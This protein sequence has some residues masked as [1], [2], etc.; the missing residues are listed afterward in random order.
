MYFSVPRF[1]L[2]ETEDSSYIDIPSWKEKCKE[3]GGIDLAL[4][5]KL[6]EFNEIVKATEKR[7]SDYVLLNLK[8]D[9]ARDSM[10][11][12]NGKPVILR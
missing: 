10:F 11:K 4:T 1:F 3:L 5:V 2:A 7:K 12:A 6:D 9:D 8:K